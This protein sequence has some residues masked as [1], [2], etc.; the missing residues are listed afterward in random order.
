VAGPVHYAR[1]VWLEADYRV[2]DADGLSAAHVAGI[3]ARRASATIGTLARARAIGSDEVRVAVAEPVGLADLALVTRRDAGRLALY[4][5][6]ADAL[7][8]A[9]SRVS[10]ALRRNDSAA[11]LISQGPGNAPP[12]TA[13]G[14]PLRAALKLAAAHRPAVLVEGSP[15]SRAAVVAG[16]DSGAR[17]YVLRD[18][19]ALSRSDIT[20]ASALFGQD[21]QP[22]IVLQFTAR[23]AQAFH[24]LTAE[25]ARRGALLSGPRLTLNQHL[26]AV[27]DG[28]LL[29]VVFVD[30]SRYPDGIPSANGT[31]IN[32]G[33]T[34][35]V[36][37]RLAAEIAA[38]PL[39][40]DLKLISSTTFTRRG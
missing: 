2:R 21:G 8:P 4:D 14:L 30:F 35:A 40:A 33:F 16:E 26:A 5:W 19:A 6:E 34:I 37:E 17:Y 15:P 1:R 9:G 11:L 25:I 29:S 32:G 23:G 20:S 28:K 24:R 10:A 38:P 36:A 7:T 27:L 3:V 39:P 12:G 18:H 13:G 22:E 31:D